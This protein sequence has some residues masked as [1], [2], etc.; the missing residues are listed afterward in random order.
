M[1][2]RDERITKELKERILKIAQLLDFRVFGSRA[3]GDENEY[4]DMD[5][6]IGAVSKNRCEH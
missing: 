1:K 6:F 5:V 4:S 2:Q 3:R